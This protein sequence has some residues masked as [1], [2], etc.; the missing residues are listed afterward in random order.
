MASDLASGTDAGVRD[1][2][3]LPP[4]QPLDPA[5]AA[6]LKALGRVT[7]DVKTFHNRT[8]GIATVTAHLPGGNRWNV[9]LIDENGQWKIG[10]ARELS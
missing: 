1:A 10:S 9:T 4:T 5:A 6:R 3:A 8:D 7:F 2:V